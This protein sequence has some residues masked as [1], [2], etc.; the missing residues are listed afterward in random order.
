MEIATIFE[1][2]NFDREEAVTPFKEIYPLVKN[3]FRQFCTDKRIDYDGERTITYKKTKITFYLNYS[4]KIRRYF[5]CLVPANIWDY[6]YKYL[7]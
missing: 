4:P 3:Y 1:S 6:S 2:E 5:L 7:W